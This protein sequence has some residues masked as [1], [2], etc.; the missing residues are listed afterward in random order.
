MRRTL[1]TTEKGDA[2]LLSKPVHTRCSASMPKRGGLDLKNRS[3]KSIWE[4]SSGRELDRQE[5]LSRGEPE[6][7]PK[8]ERPSNPS[9]KG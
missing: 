6:G 3:E 8:N 1:E 5:P 9:T 4:S 2:T 7:G